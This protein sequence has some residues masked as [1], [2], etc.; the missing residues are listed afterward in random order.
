MLIVNYLFDAKVAK[1]GESAKGK[2]EYFEILLSTAIINYEKF[3][4][5]TVC[6]WRLQNHPQMKN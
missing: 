1:G 4:E 3:E 6:L 5:L 2:G